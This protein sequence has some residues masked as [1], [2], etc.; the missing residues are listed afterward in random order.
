MTKLSSDVDPKLSNVMVEQ[1]QRQHI[2]T[3]IQFIDEDAEKL[4]TFTGLSLKDILQIKQNIF[5]KYGGTVQN[6]FHLFET[7]RNNIIP[8]KISS[9]DNLLKGG[10]YPGHIYEICGLSASGKTQLCF[11]IATNVALEPHNCVRYIDTK[12]DFCGS[13]I[14]QILVQ[15][16]CS[17]QVINETM[18]RIKV[19]SIYNLHQLFKVLR[20]LTVNLREESERCR[21]RT[22]IIDCLPAIIFQLPRCYRPITAALNHLANICH[23]ITKEFNLSI[24]SVNLITQWNE[25]GPS[26]S[27]NENCSEVTPTL[28]KYWTH[29][30]NTRLLLEKVRPGSRKLSIWKSSQV[31]EKLS[32]NL[33]ISDSGILCC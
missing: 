15:K 16:G 31:E 24:I 22:I 33:R 30:P 4:A 5:K 8:T 25:E 1:L 19:C 26:T 29:V 10:L 28:G 18:E 32:C 7:E 12:R 20:W 21:T 11:A 27:S 6:A 9:L 17:K 23:S 2:S 14:E 3:L 13:R